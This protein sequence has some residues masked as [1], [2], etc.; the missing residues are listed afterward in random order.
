[1]PVQSENVEVV[2]A[3]L[4]QKTSSKLTA[5]GKLERALN[6]EFDKM[7]QLNKRA[8]YQMFETTQADGVAMPAVLGRL[9]L[10]GDELLVLSQTY[11]FAVLDGTETLQSDTRAMVRRGYISHGNVSTFPVTVSTDAEP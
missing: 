7:G 6:V 3:G 2:F 10:D 5:P 11:A 9:V 1:M 8:G 4:D